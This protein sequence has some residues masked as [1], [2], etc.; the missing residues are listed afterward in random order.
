MPILLLLLLGSLAPAVDVWAAGSVELTLLPSSPRSSVAPPGEITGSVTLLTEGRPPVSHPVSSWDPLTVVV[1]DRVPTRIRVDAQGY[2]AAEEIVLPTGE[3]VEKSLRLRPAGVLKGHVALPR[4][5][6]LPTSLSVTLEPAE[7]FRVQRS[8]AAGG[9]PFPPTTQSCPVDSHG[10]WVCAAPAGRLDL[11]LRVKGYVSEYRWGARMDAG[12]ILDLGE[13]VLRPGASVVGW[14]RTADRSPLQPGARASLTPSTAGSQLDAEVAGVDRR[15]EST[16]IDRRGFFHFEGVAPGSYELRVE[17]EGFAPTERSPVTVLE[18]RETSLP[19]PLVLDRPVRFEVALVPPVDPYGRPWR[20]G[21]DPRDAGTGSPPEPAGTDGLWARA[22]LAPGSYRLTVESGQGRY[23]Y[24]WWSEEVSI[25]AGMPIYELRL[26]VVEVVGTVR[27]GSEP[28]EAVVRFGGRFGARR[29]DFD[30]DTEGRFGGYLPEEGEWRVSVYSKETG[31]RNLPPIPVELPSGERLAEVDIR[32]PDLT[33]RGE[34]VD[35]EGQPVANATVWAH[36]LDFDRSRERDTDRTATDE[37][38]EF[39][40][41]G[42]EAGPWLVSAQSVSPEGTS[43]GVAVELGEGPTPEP[44]RL[45]LE[46]WVHVEARLVSASGP[47]AGARVGVTPRVPGEYLVFARPTSISDADGRVRFTYP[48]RSAGVDLSILPPGFAA[49]AR[50]LPSPLP[51]T[52]TVQVSQE[53]GTLIL[54]LESFSPDLPEGSLPPALL[55]H[56]DARLSLASARTW[57]RLQRADAPSDGKLRI[58][59]M[60]PGS[61]TLCVSTGTGD[62]GRHCAQGTLPPYGQLELGRD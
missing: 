58:P 26:P 27:L 29:L 57:A 11:R 7:P 28:V 32:I 49:Q 23:E 37:E 25:E 17:Q 9:R 50:F 42:L 62:E 53:G 3:P 39:Q 55:L 1:P 13:L 54:D 14:V 5:E 22:G 4:G 46:R 41:R 19:E 36:P 59:R 15:T 43:A 6:S 18:G 2:W 21:L 12:K 38:G 31:W 44:V 40:L 48:R 24:T 60:A 10:G 33:L 35:A 56:D 51:E 45:T 61:Y 47:V 8:R 30:S 52:I 34:V 20:L 16:E